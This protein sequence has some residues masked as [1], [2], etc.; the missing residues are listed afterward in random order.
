[1]HRAVVAR[2]AHVCGAGVAADLMQGCT[3]HGAI[4]PPRLAGRVATRW[5]A[6]GLARSLLRLLLLQ[7]MKCRTEGRV[8]VQEVSRSPCEC[9]GLLGQNGQE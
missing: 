4:R 2:A 8:Q 7:G 9:W 1:V 5:L 6:L 3:T